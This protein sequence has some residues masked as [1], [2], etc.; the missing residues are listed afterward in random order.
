[1]SF[2]LWCQRTDIAMSVVGSNCCLCALPLQ[3][4]HYVVSPGD[5][6]NFLKIY[7][8]CEPN[9]GHEWQRGERPFPFG[10]EHEWLAS[11]VA[12][13]RFDDEPALL[14]GTV[15]DGRLTDAE[16]VNSA[17]VHSGCYDYAAF[18][19]VCWQMMGSPRAACDAWYSVVDEERRSS[20]GIGTYEWAL[21]ASYHEQLFD[22]FS[23]ERDGRAWLLTDP[24][25]SSAA[26]AHS[27]ARIE[28]ALRTAKRR[29]A[30]NERPDLATVADVLFEDCDWYGQSN[31]DAAGQRIQVIRARQAARPDLDR[32]GYDHLVWMMTEYD[33]TQLLAHSDLEAAL[34]LEAAIKQAIEYDGWGVLVAGMVTGSHAQYVMQ[35]K[36]GESTR[37]RIE[38]LP[39]ARSPPRIEFEFEVDPSWSATFRLLLG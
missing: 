14:M 7:R 20:R 15:T 18:H 11:A 33:G 31:C 30:P 24:R 10:P 17:S 37:R 1:L 39:E 29:I 13:A 26:A 25:G 3:H 16:G 6:G 28:A 2:N 4:D 22:I 9:G 21:L 19:Q 34:Q 27:R 38:A 5:V 35:T 36:D 8:G 32:T 12:L 23:M